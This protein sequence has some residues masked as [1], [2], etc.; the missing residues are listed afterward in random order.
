MA[1]IIP[2]PAAIERRQRAANRAGDTMCP[3]VEA[4]IGAGQHETIDAIPKDDGS[5]LREAEILFFTG[6]R[7]SRAQ[8]AEPAA[9]SVTYREMEEA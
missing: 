3:E 4:Q 6:V 5:V 9:A 1:D 7:Y 2:F 8:S